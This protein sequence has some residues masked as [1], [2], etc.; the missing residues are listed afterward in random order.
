MTAALLSISDLHVAGRRPES[1]WKPILN[2]VSVEIAN[3]E[4]VALI[5]ES[6]AGKTTLALSALGYARAGTRF[7]S[8]R[9]ELGGR[10]VLTLPRDGKR[11]FRGRDVAYVAQS[12]AA[13]LNPSMTIGRQVGEGL[14]LHGLARVSDA[15]KRVNELLALLQLPDPVRLAQRY[16]QQTSGGQQQRVWRWP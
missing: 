7:E 14:V 1:G 5:G 6:G 15:R 13:A 12:A 4:I 11:A 8:G 2:G 3:G 9:V 10:D 16:P